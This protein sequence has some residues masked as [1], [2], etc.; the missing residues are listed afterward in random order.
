M[1]SS[2]TPHTTTTFGHDLYK[3]YGGSAPENYERYFVPAIGGPFAT[4]LIEAA[5]LRP[6]ERVLD[7][8]C[9]TGIVARRAAERVGPTGAVAGLDLNPGML[10]VAR[11]A[12]PPDGSIEWH[13]ASAE[14]MPLPDETFDVV[15][16]QLGLQFVPDKSAAL[17][18]MRR[19]LSSGGRLVLSVVGPTPPAFAIM[20]QALAR[21]IN[22]GISAFVRMVFSLHDPAELKRLID[23]AGFRDVAVKLT[24]KPLRLPPPAE[25]LWQYIWSTP[26]IDAV[27]QADDASRAALERE[28]VEGWQPFTQDGALT[29][30]PQ[31]VIATAR[32]G[33]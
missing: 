20:E 3:A 7:V 17:R 11:S 32:R 8:A 26:L 25:F 33:H 24:P 31:M 16:C 6:G 5:A 1:S 23:D 14:A 29:I 22:P 21:H 9:G 15:L 4:D 19:V 28:V 27:S 2:A 12:A 10:A 30:V 18:E 13:R